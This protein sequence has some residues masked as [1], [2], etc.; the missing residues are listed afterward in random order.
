MPGIKYCHDHSETDSRHGCEGVADLRYTM[1]FDN[2]GQPPIY[3]CAHC[4]ADAHKINEAIQKAVK[5][6]GP[7]F[8]KEFGRA[9]KKAEGD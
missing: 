1:Y 7:E 3:W 9:I 6:R 2:I 4:G 5:E 8:I